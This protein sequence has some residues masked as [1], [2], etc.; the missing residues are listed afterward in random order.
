[1][2]VPRLLRLALGRSGPNPN[3][4]EVEQMHDV[5]VADLA[6]LVDSQCQYGLPL[7]PTSPS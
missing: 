1:V 7:V 6:E 4:V 3:G 2:P 5:V